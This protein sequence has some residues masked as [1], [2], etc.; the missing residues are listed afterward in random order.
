MTGD[1]EFLQA[2]IEGKIR[3]QEQLERMM[4]GQWTTAYSTPC[5]DAYLEEKGK[6]YGGALK[7]AKSLR[8]LK[9]RHKGRKSVHECFKLLIGHKN[10]DH[11]FVAVQDRT[12]RND[13]RSLPGLPILFI[14]GST[15]LMEPPTDKSNQQAVKVGHPPF[16]H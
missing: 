7:I 10:K 11:L 3:V 12:I 1:G 14:N 9:C 4:D 8:H 15:P 16:Q 5:V 2:A 13:V 6:A